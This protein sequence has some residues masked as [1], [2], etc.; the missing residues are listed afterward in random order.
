MTKLIWNYT[1][2]A[3]IFGRVR[4]KEYCLIYKD[5]NCYSLPLATG[6][7]DTL[8]ILDATNPVDAI[9]EA[10]RILRKELDIGLELDAMEVIAKLTPG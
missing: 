1:N 5:P 2:R 7:I 3:S 8:I 4:G 6:P 10:K 9:K